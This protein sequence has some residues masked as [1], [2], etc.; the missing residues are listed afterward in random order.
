MVGCRTAAWDVDDG[1]ASV[2]G[3]VETD[4]RGVGVGPGVD[5]LPLQAAT[6]ATTK[7]AAKKPNP[8]LRKAII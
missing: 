8:A 6:R 3:G 7:R 1:A 5:V 2:A 4:A